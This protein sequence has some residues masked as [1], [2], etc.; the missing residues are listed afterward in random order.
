MSANTAV[1]G[2][3]P[4]NHAVSL[5]LNVEDPLAVLVDRSGPIA[6]QSDYHVYYATTNNRMKSFDIL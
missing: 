6:Q 5:S 2:M 1:Q 3:P 4:R